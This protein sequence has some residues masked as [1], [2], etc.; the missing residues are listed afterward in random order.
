MTSYLRIALSLVFLMLVLSLAAAADPIFRAES[1]TVREKGGF[2]VKTWKELGT[3][4]AQLMITAGCAAYGVDCSKQAA[5][6]VE[7]ARE[8]YKRFNTSS[9]TGTAK[10]FWQEGE[11]WKANIIPPKGYEV[12]RVGVYTNSGSITGESTFNAS[13][14]W[15]GGKGINIYA[16]VPKGR[17]EGHWASFNM[18]AKYVPKSEVG[19]SKHS[20]WNNSTVFIACSGGHQNCKIS[21][22][23]KG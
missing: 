23:L 20:C 12:C 11:E 4:E 15:Q 8:S 3:E 17:K 10:I 21:K 9:Y 1:F 16:V 6:I 22:R 18:L 13:V 14:R 2:G 7:A 19:K 5:A